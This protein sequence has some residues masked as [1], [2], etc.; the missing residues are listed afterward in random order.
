MMTAGQS[1]PSVSGPP[2]RH[3]S[4][5][6]RTDDH[7]KVGITFVDVLF[8]LVV[9]RILES[10][11]DA[12]SLPAPAVSHL[13]VATVLTVFSWI[14]Y[15]NSTYRPQYPI[16]F[17]NLP[18]W[19]FL[20]DILLVGLYWLA[21][22]T[23]EYIPE[24]GRLNSPTSARSEVLIV[25]ASFVLYAVWDEVSRRINRSPNYLD[26]DESSERTR[27]RRVTWIFGLAVVAVLILTLLWQPR[28]GSAVVALDAVLIVLLLLYRIAK[29]WPAADPRRIG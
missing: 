10:A 3:E 26:D 9:G 15:H 16:R 7:L 27:R 24:G 19:Q 12:G 28:A 1:N 23:A 29:D 13:L 22:T 25:T 6:R 5:A 4:G 21:A 2:R 14:G 8:A 18:F 11:T 20:I 17:I